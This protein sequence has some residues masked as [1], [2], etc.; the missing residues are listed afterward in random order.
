MKLLAVCL[1]LSLVAAAACVSQAEP[2]AAAA[3]NAETMYQAED[4]IATLMS[5]NTM[6]NVGDSTWVSVQLRVDKATPSLKA[7]ATVKTRYLWPTSRL[8]SAPYQGDQISARLWQDPGAA[9]V[10]NISEQPKVIGRGE[11]LRPGENPA[12]DLGSPKAKLLIKMLAP[13]QAEC[14]Q[15]TATLLRELAARE[16]ERVHVQIFDMRTPSGRQEMAKERL[17]C[18]SVLVNN[19]FQFTIEGPS[20]PRKA[21]FQHK[22]NEL[23][24]PYNSEDVITVADQELKRLYPKG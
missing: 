9:G 24:S 4:V 17:N 10:W 14:H 1:S 19:Q 18:A 23:N 13:L 5:A 11:F 12:E 16:P 7:G 21:L 3:A 6:Y 8:R 2:A 15:K 20:G 22:P